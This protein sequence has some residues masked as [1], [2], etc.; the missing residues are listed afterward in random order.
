MHHCDIGPTLIG[1]ANGTFPAET[2][3]APDGMNMWPYLMDPHGDTSPRKT[4]ILNVDQTNEQALN[5]PH[6]WSG[7]AGTTA[8]SFILAYCI[9]AG[10]RM[11][12]WKLVLGYP[13]VPDGW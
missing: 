10:I 11:G 5:D 13:G 1:A 7:Y 6:G 9:N 4:V 3:P 12:Q 8:L 2:S